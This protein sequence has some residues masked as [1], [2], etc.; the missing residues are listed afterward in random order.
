MASATIS[1]Q[2]PSTAA[3]GP[4]ERRGHGVQVNQPG[5]ASLADGEPPA[6]GGSCG[7]SHALEGGP[8]AKFW[9][10]RTIFA[11]FLRG[12]AAGGM[13]LFE[14]RTTDRVRSLSAAVPVVATTHGATGPW[15]RRTGCCVIASSPAT[16][17]RMT[18]TFSGSTARTAFPDEGEASR[19]ASSWRPASRLQRRDHYCC[20]HRG[21]TVPGNSTSIRS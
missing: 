13:G 21:T 10:T 2:S 3:R 16:R 1:G 19:F 4:G 6:R 15:T 5:A 9:R 20:S 17:S 11:R 18:E 8:A 7:A 14:R 12:Y